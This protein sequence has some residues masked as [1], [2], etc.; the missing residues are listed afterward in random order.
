[1]Q[2]SIIIPIYNVSQYVERCIMSVIN[3]TFKDLD[4]ILV[5]DCGTDD[6]MD[7][8]LQT[9]RQTEIFVEKNGAFSHSS[10]KLSINIIH[11]DHNRGLSAARNTGIKYAQGECLYFLD[12]DDY[13]L[14]DCIE[15]MAGL[16]Q[17]YPDSQIVFAGANGTGRYEFLDYTKKHLPEYSDDEEWLS[18][19]MLKR[20]SLSM[21]AWNRLISKSFVIENNLFFEEGYVHEDEIWNLQIAQRIKRAS[22][23]CKNTYMYTVRDGSLITSCACDNERFNKNH[24]RLWL[25]MVELVDDKR[26]NL[27]IHSILTIVGNNLRKV[28]SIKYIGSTNHILFSS[29]KKCRGAFRFQ[30]IKYIIAWNILLVSKVFTC[31]RKK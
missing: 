25:R 3:Q 13:I 15:R 17:K 23:L 1:M 10:S 29:L 30:V 28:D 21:T 24:S 9:I 20:F 8:A 26:A 19:T 7:I 31:N 27:Q 12:S 11:H 2:V 6:S 18:K 14:P 4:V 22:F 16:L 5:D